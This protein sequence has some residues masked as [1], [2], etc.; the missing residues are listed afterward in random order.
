ML[1]ILNTS[2]LPKPITPLSIIDCDDIFKVDPEFNVFV[3][4]PTRCSSYR[5]DNFYFVT[6]I[7]KI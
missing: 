7:T 6:I 3:L 4:E 2:A 1:L 5:C